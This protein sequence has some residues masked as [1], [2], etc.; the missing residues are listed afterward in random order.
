M[1][2]FY[3]GWYRKVYSIIGKMYRDL[4]SKVSY[5]IHTIII[6]LMV[7]YFTPF[8]LV[9]GNYVEIDSSFVLISNSIFV[10][11]MAFIHFKRYYPYSKTKIIL[12]KDLVDNRPARALCIILMIS[13]WIVAIYTN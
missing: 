9:I 4:D 10:V 11:V 13:L 5:T 3:D 7:G 2:S 1:L 12:T 8:L 6:I